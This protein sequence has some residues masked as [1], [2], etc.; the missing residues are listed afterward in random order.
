[1]SSSL[2]LG[3]SEGNA[4]VWVTGPSFYMFV[5]LAH[6]ELICCLSSLPTS[7]TSSSSLISSRPVGL[8]PEDGL[9]SS[10]ILVRY[11]EN[12]LSKQEARES[13]AGFTWKTLMKPLAHVGKFFLLVW[14]GFRHFQV[15]VRGA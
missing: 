9:G 6:A 14:F 5:S 13:L 2:G 11:K 4:G 10:Y 15:K 12:L 1:M 7:W 8:D 3:P